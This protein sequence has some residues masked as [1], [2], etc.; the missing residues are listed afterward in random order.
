MSRSDKPRS[1]DVR[2]RIGVLDGI[3]GIAAIAVVLIHALGSKGW[4][5]SV[6]TR[7]YTSAWGNLA[8]D[9]FFCMS[10]YLITG[11]LIREKQRTGTIAV[12]RFY[13]RRAFRVFP[14]YLVYV[15][16]V[17]V[18]GAL[19][20]FVVPWQQTVQAL[21]FTR[22]FFGGPP[23]A[24]GILWSLCVE[25]VFYTFWP[26]V[27][28]RISIR[29]LKRV[30]ALTIVL[31]PFLRA[32]VFYCLAYAHS[33]VV[34]EIWRLPTGVIDIVAAGALFSLVENDPKFMELAR[35]FQ[36]LPVV[37]FGGCMIWWLLRQHGGL[38]TEHGVGP[39]TFTIASARAFLAFLIIHRAMTK[40]NLLLARILQLRI[41]RTIGAFSYSIY[42]AHALFINR[43]SG[44]LIHAF[45][46]VLVPSAIVAYLMQRLVADPF[47]KARDR[48]VPEP[49][50]DR[51]PPESGRPPRG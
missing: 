9:L 32:F 24:Y 26:L 51:S 50:F 45:P 34:N 22:E 4:P 25:E 38:S 2:S 31:S 5:A 21:T 39:A 14:L 43:E 37:V 1:A 29:T 30:L 10:G 44:N 40:P 20:W 49:R 18:L 12:L 46:V 3:R 35:Y 33:P 19:G 23:L 47:M 28:R 15:L 6:A 8:V 27:V 17:F 16:A 41:L 42:L 13:K 11:M 7:N 36:R 48:W